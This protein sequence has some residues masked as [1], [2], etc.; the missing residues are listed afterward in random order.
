MCFCSYLVIFFIHG[1]HF[2]YTLYAVVVE[3]LMQNISVMISEGKDPSPSGWSSLACKLALANDLALFA[4]IQLRLLEAPKI[5]VS[6][7]KLIK[8]SFIQY[9]HL[10]KV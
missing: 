6:Q 8:I 4:L 9:I 5:K 1:L 3:T 2:Q 7:N 10:K